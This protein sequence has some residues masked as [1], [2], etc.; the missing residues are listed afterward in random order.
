MCEFNVWIPPDVHIDHICRVRPC[1]NP[2][3]HDPVEPIENFR[4]GDGPK[5][6]FKSTRQ[7]IAETM[8]ELPF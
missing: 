2:F 3:H 1:I 5:Y 8:D 7:K 6:T 4:R